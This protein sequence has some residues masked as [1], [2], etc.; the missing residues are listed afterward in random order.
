MWVMTSATY[1]IAKRFEE[2]HKAIM[3]ADLLTCSLNAH[4]WHQIGKNSLHE[5]NRDRAIDAFKR[6]LSIDPEHIATHISLSSVYLSMRQFEL[7]EQLL[8]RS[9]KGL[10]WNETESW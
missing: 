3:E 8:E 6:A 2:A 9:T 7:V 4:V 5:G 1:A 10:G